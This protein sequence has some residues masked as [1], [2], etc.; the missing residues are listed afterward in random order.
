[1]LAGFLAPVKYGL[2]LGAVAVGPPVGAPTVTGPRTTSDEQ[3][4]Y[5]FRAAHAVSFRCAF[6]SK[7][8]HFCSA[9][10]SERLAPGSHVLRVRAVPR[11]GALSRVVTV[12]IAITIPYPALA[13]GT[14]LQVGGGAGVPTVEGGSVW[15][16]LTETGE[17]ARVDPTAGTVTGK[18]RVGVPAAGRAGFLDAAVAAGGAV[19]SA[20]DA[21]GTVARV[22]TAPGTPAVTIAAGTRPGGLVAGGGAVWTFGFSAPTSPGSTSRP[23]LRRGS[24]STARLRPGSRTAPACSGC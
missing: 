18:T 6:D 3:P 7:A 2:L 8:L 22:D 24:T 13:S 14:A 5:R 16:P 19:W 4:V 10:Y 15:V 9:R 20:S 17:L 21:G 12:K 1:M 11:R 23:L